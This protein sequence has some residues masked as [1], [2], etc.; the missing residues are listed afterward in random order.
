M[1][2][3]LL[4]TDV[5]SKLIEELNTETVFSLFGGKLKIDEGTVVSWIIMAVFLIA[6]ILLTRGLKVEGKLSKRQLFIDVRR[7]NAH[8]LPRRYGPGRGSLHSLDDD[9]SCLYRCLQYVRHLRI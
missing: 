5:A 6:G 2:A 1:T 4:K 7:Q 3:L 9:G 8:I